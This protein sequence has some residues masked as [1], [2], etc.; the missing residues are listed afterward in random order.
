LDTNVGYELATNAERMGR[1]VKR[2]YMEE[3]EGGVQR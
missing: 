2:E 3:L 1:R